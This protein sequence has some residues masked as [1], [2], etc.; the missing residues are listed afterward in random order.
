MALSGLSTDSFADY[1]NLLQTDNPVLDV[2]H[3]LYI[4]ILITRVYT[5]KGFSYY[6]L[7]N[8]ENRMENGGNRMENG[9][10][11]ME[12]GGNPV[13]LIRNRSSETV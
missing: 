6:P 1:Y 11:R 13:C 9:G 12:N 10:N 5:I 2:F 7:E 3:Y 8:G 4:S